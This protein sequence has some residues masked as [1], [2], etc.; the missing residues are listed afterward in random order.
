MLKA[1]ENVTMR[2]LTPNI[3]SNAAAAA[4][5]AACRT[6]S[7]SRGATFFFFKIT[8]ASSEIT[9]KTATTIIHG[10]SHE[11]GTKD[12]GEAGSRSSKLPDF[13]FIG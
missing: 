1:E 9:N 8:T 3:L 6:A 11:S 4:A 7:G 2:G 12:S 5:W 10:S 13:S